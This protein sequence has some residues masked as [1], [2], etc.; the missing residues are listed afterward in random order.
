MPL[1][2]TQL[3]ELRWFFE[4]RRIRM[5]GERGDGQFERARRAFGPRVFERCIAPGSNR[6]TVCSTRSS[7]PRLATAIAR[8]TGKFEATRTGASI[9]PSRSSGWH[10]VI[11]GD[12][13]CEGEETGVMTPG[14]PSPPFR[15]R[16]ELRNGV[17]QQGHVERL[18]RRL[19]A[20][21][22]DVVGS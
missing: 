5:R 16:N 14:G 22:L 18:A 11:A 1:R 7:R 9:S 20:T 3:D 19:L 21:P 13:E 15:R 4:A 2:P 6:E 8:Q 10:G 17:R 12:S